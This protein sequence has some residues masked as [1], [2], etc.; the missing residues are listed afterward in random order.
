[1]AYE[2][3]LPHPPGYGQLPAYYGHVPAF[4]HPPAP[5]PPELPDGASPWPRWPWWYGIAAGFSGFF[6]AMIGAAIVAAAIAAGGGDTDGGAFNQIATV[7]FDACLVGAAVFFASRTQRPRLWHFGLR[8]ARFWPTVGWAALGMVSFWIFA[9]AYSGIVNPKGEQETLDTL[10]VDK[11]TV[12]LVG[13]AVLVIVVAPLAEELFFRAFFYRALRTRLPVWAAALIDGALF[14]AIH[15][16]NPRMLTI[17]PILGM[18]GVIF[19]LI[20]ERTGT[21]FATVSL[22]ALNNFIAFG[23]STDEWAVAGIVGGT[24]LLACT[25]LPR[26][27]LPAHAPALR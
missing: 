18:L 7:V 15:Y 5:D 8:R 23:G 21:I 17:L 20:Y 10:G 24:M 6:V 16:E 12:A 13:A 3:P 22:H 9:I 14:G 4:P 11:S 25:S 26:L 27:L 2:Q 1:M 19:C